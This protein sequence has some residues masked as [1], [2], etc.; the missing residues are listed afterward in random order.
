MNETLDILSPD[1]PENALQLLTQAIDALRTGDEQPGGYMA[2]AIIQMM[3]STELRIQLGEGTFDLMIDEFRQRLA[4]FCRSPENIIDLPGGKF[5]L[6]LPDLTSLDHLELATTKLKRTLSPPINVVNHAVLVQTNA[7][8]AVTRAAVAKPGLLFQ[9]AES[10]LSR[11]TPSERYVIYDPESV[12]RESDTWSLKVELEEALQRGELVPYF[13]PVFSTAFHSVIAAASTLA[14]KSSKRGLVSFSK[15][16]AGANDCDML[17]PVYWQYLK[18]A[19]GQAN[20][21][22]DTVGVIVQ[23]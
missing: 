16:V 8:F 13:E 22:Q 9:A 2:C 1:I 23:S 14:W 15:Y 3:R 7:G 17:R 10:A 20:K 19:I 12:S 5:C 4:D 6:V 11:C 21:W 18:G